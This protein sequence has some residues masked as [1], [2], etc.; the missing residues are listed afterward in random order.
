MNSSDPFPFPTSERHEPPHVQ[1]V[2][3][4]EQPLTED[5]LDHGIEESF[6]ASDPVSVN[7]TKAAPAPKPAVNTEGANRAADDAHT[8]LALRTGLATGTFAGIACSIALAALGRRDAKRSM[9]WVCGAFAAGLAL[10]CATGD[11][12]IRLRTRKS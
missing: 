6:P 8:H 9:A 7:V 11:R 10:G 5:A 12:S 3:P 4:V 2:R 1:H